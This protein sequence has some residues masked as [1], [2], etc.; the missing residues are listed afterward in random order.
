MDTTVKYTTETTQQ[1]VDAYKQGVAVGDLALQFGVPERSII[2]KLSSLG[3]YRKKVYHNKNGEL[4]V[5]KEVYIQQIADLLHQDPELCE[6]LEKVN[7][8][9]LQMLVVALQPKQFDE[10]EL[11]AYKVSSVGS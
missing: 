9:V 8:R 10:L 4:P 11:N 6:S 2:A 3:V 1:L 5:K 7:K